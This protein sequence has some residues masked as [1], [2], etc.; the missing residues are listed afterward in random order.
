MYNMLK[1]SSVIIVDVVLS[2]TRTPLLLFRLL[3][4]IIQYL[5]M[6]SIL[7]NILSVNNCMQHEK[8]FL[9]EDN[10]IYIY[11]WFS[12]LNNF[13]LLWIYSYQNLEKPVVC[14]RTYLHTKSTGASYVCVPPTN[15]NTYIVHKVLSFFVR[16]RL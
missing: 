11:K 15:L 6:I 8:T 5:Y 12:C 3:T 9:T 4:I 7:N 2:S 13:F 16:L 1:D 10:I 14:V